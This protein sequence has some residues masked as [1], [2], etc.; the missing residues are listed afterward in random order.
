MATFENP[1]YTENPL[2]PM[3]TVGK[4]LRT[5]Q[6]KIDITA[7]SADNDVIVLAKGIPAAAR[8]VHIMLPKGS[9]ALTGASVDIGLYRMRKNLSVSEDDEYSPVEYVEVDGDCLVDGQS[10]ASAL[11]NVDI[12]GANISSFKEIANLATL[13]SASTGE[14]PSGGYVI[15]AKLAAKGSA[16]GSIY[17]DVVIEQN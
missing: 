14:E 9:T 16:T 5:V 4:E 17:I 13:A 3:F 11:N 15:G 12:L 10:F 7:E 6:A 2:D 8:V 1:F